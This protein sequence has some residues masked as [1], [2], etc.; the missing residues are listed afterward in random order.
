MTYLLDSD[1]FTLGQYGRRGVASRIDTVRSPD[2]VGL[3]ELTRAEVLKGRVA[4]VMVPA[5]GSG[6][7]RAVELLRT[8]E[9]YITRFPVVPFDHAAA[10]HFDRLRAG[11]KS[12]KGGH[13][14]LLIA[15]IALAHDA[16]LVTPN[17][18][19]FAGVPGLRVENWAD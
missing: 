6:A 12:W 3:P 14:D 17:L 7:L 1:T 10:A 5:D 19:D 13:V 2:A 16:T 9:K 8:T 11:K 15:C 4:A 18:K